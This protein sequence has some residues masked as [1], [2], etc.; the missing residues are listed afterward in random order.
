MNEVYKPEKESI[1]NNINEIIQATL[2]GDHT[3]LV[4]DG[5]HTF[6]EL[7]HHRAILFASL[8]NVLNNTREHSCKTWKSKKHDDSSMFE[9]YFIVGIS[10]PYGNATY[11][12]SLK[13]WNIF[14]C[15]EID[16]APKFDGHTPDEALRRIGSLCRIF[17][18]NNYDKDQFI[19]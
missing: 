2:P 16:N 13:Y 8:I 1:A 3:N 19:N 11:H 14:K 18:Y 6:G 10:T 7:Y 4:S 5:S 15:Q 9:G 12:Y 17:E